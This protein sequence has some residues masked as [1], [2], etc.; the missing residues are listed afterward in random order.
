MIWHCRR[1]H[2]AGGVVHII[3]SVNLIFI[4]CKSIQILEI[5][6]VQVNVLFDFGEF[7]V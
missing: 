6:Y 1:N 3:V 2:S 4:D 7:R 5:C